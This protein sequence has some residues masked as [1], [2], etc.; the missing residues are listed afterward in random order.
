MGGSRM[1]REQLRPT[2]D[3]GAKFFIR[4]VMLLI[5]MAFC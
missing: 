5:E 1:G 3:S 2:E 4:R